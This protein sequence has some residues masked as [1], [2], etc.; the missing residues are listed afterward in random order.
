MSTQ[1]ILT[2]A[3]GLLATVAVAQELPCK[4]S[5]VANSLSGEDA[6][7]AQDIADIEV[8]PDGT[9]FTNVPWEEGGSNVQQ[10]AGGKFVRDARHTHG[11][12]YEGGSAVAA[13]TRY[14][15]V[16]QGVENEG[17]GLKGPSWPAKGLRWTGV[18]RRLR[19]DIRKPAPFEGG[20]G[21]DGDTL[22]GAFLPIVEFPEKAEGH[23]AP[24]G[25]AASDSR[26]YV[27][28]P[29]DNTVKLFNAETLK[30][31]GSFALES[32]GKISID[33]AGSIYAIQRKP[34]APSIVKLAPDGKV[35]RTLALPADSVPLDISASVDGKILVSDGGPTQ[36]VRIL[37]ADLT[38]RGTIGVAGGVLAG[39]TPGAVGDLRFNKPT[40]VGIDAQGSIYVASSGSVAGGSSVLECYGPDLKLRW[41]QL[42]LT[43]VD[44]VDL[45]PADDTALYSK[46]KLFTL[47]YSQP[48]GKQWT[49]TAYT[50]DAL[51][52]P[53]DPRLHTGPTH[54]WVRRLGRKP[55]LFVT[56]MTGEFL[57]VYRYDQKSDGYIAIPSALFSRHHVK[58]RESG[59]PANQPAADAWLWTDRNGNGRMDAGE[60]VVQPSRGELFWPDASGG[61]WQERAGT[62]T[63]LPFDKLT[64]QGVPTWAMDKSRVLPKP[65]EFTAVRR[66]HYQPEQ[67]LLMLAGNNAEHHNQHW[68]PMGPILAAYDNALSA[69]P[70]L[71]WK[72]TLPYEVGSAGHESREPI[73]FDV[74]GDYV[75]VA[76]TRGMKADNVTNAYIKVYSLADGAFVGN[77][78]AERYLGEGG[79][80][81]LV[82][83]VRAIRRANGEY[84]VFLEEDMKAK[85]IMFQWTP[86]R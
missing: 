16:A 8:T 49:Y 51:K 19:S 40:G 73:S 37:D 27:A 26:L 39:P 21:G 18:S 55:M 30:L 85:V 56:D 80:L 63:Y 53:D 17:G 76:Y 9:V 42:G 2:L 57:S 86:V 6:W 7:V 32:P 82:E 65:A 13:N 33:P 29:N 67:D 50:V 81:D 36:Q 44:L 62:I 60:Y 4:V 74:A 78:V 45:D 38:P 48:A 43:F 14:V 68:K 10:Y 22:K 66:V 71:R 58:P 31:E 5:W 70:R 61:I 54:V 35:L 23:H 52:Y 11:W 59:W 20:R 84:V 34:G 46:D 12:G 47:D 79:L 64:D 41:R 69:A 15:F 24:S 75:F 72:L 28:C 25:L 77:L 3:A 1:P 83:S